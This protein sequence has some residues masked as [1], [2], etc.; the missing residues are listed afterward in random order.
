MKTIFKKVKKNEAGAA[1]VEFALILPILLLLMIGSIEVYRYIYI[2]QKVEEISARIADWSAAKTSLLAIQDFFYGAY[3][4]GVEFNFKANGGVYVTGI[5]NL[6]GINTA[7]WT[8]FTSNAT[9]QYGRLGAIVTLPSPLSLS[10]GDNLIIVEV[11]YKYTPLTSYLS[12]LT[13]K[14]IRSASF[15]M[16]RGMSIF[17]PLPV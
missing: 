13:S 17:Y 4:L 9:T 10:S 1:L 7:M 12:F 2:T 16:P 6:L 8:V 14:T 3:N 11:T 5:Q 15:S